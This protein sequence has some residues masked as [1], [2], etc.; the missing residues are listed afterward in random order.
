MVEKNEASDA[1]YEITQLITKVI[2]ITKMYIVFRH[3]NNNPE[4]RVK[5]NT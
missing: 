4:D 3:C 5:F 2:S 1:N